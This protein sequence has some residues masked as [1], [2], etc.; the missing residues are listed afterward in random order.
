MARINPDPHRAGYKFQP[1]HAVTASFPRGV[2][3]AALEKALTEA[4]IAPDQVHIFQGTP[5]AAW[6]DLRGEAHGSWVQLRRK[7]EHM[8]EPYESWVFDQAEEMLRSGG[9]VVIAFTGGD[10]A[11]KAREIELLKAHGGKGVRYWGP[12]SMEI[13][14]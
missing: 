4:G 13:Y 10:D 14:F 1:T 9:T 12:K 7:M 11:L 8:F 3:I 6:L 2:D 5:G